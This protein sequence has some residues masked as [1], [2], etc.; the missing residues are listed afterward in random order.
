MAGRAG[1]Y[2]NTT[3]MYD[4][5][6]YIPCNA[7]NNFEPE[8]PKEVPDIIYLCSPNNPTGVIYSEETLKKMGEI[9]FVNGIF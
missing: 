6:I 9:L 8:L 7:E 1:K 2:N 3:G 4:N 5:I